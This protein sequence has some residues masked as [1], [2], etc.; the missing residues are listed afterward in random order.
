M[1]RKIF[2]MVP[3][4]CNVSQILKKGENV[5]TLF[6]FFSVE[7]KAMRNLHPQF[8]VMARRWV[9]PKA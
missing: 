1:P 4:G 3:I 8:D 9:L 6:S 7:K 2:I 5:N